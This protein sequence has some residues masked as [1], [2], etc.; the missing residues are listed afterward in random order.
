[1]RKLDRTGTT[2]DI[3]K[4][5]Y[6]KLITEVSPLFYQHS[7]VAGGYLRDW[8]HGRPVKDLDI[9]IP[10]CALHHKELSK[11]IENVNEHSQITRVHDDGEYDED[12]VAVYN[13][14]GCALPVQIIFDINARS[15]DSVIQNFHNSLSRIAFNPAT[16]KI[17]KYPAYKKAV[18]TKINLYQK[19]TEPDNV[20]RLLK[21][22]SR[23]VTKYPD[24]KHIILDK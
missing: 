19:S 20:E 15:K 11:L 17:I 14:S 1:M 24:Y 9:F 12:D 10:Q 21:Y 7:I 18:L 13:M 4:Q 2:E 23:M 3:V 8:D 22:K 5:V 16:N 6:T